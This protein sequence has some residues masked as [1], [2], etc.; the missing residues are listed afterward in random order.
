MRMRNYAVH[1]FSLNPFNYDRQTKTRKC[2]YKG[3]NQKSSFIYLPH[4]HH[5]DVILCLNDQKDIKWN[6]IC[7]RYLGIYPESVYYKFVL[8]L[9][10]SSNIWTFYFCHNKICSKWRYISV[11]NPLSSL[12][13]ARQRKRARFEQNFRYLI[14]IFQ[15]LTLSIVSRLMVISAW[16]LTL[17][18]TLPQAII[19]RWSKNRPDL[20]SY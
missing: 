11:S 7:L 3:L 2:F 1:S 12:N 13:S 18:F 4:L 19:F 20:F 8:I 9:H 10:I 16:L 15:F 17:L 14:T 5:V 6:S